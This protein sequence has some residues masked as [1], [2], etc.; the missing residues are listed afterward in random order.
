MIHRLLAPS[1]S[2]YLELPIGCVL[3]MGV[4]QFIAWLDWVLP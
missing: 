1:G 2:E 3:C 4:P